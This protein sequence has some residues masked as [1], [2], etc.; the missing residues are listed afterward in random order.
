MLYSLRIFSKIDPENFLYIGVLFFLSGAVISLVP[1][2][3]VKNYIYILSVLGS[4]GFALLSLYLLFTLPL[5][6]FSLPISSIF[7]F[8]FRGDAISGFFVLAISILTLAVSIYSIGY[9]KEMG[10]KGLMG[11]LFN[12]FILSMYAVVLSGNIVTFIMSWETMS[13]VSYFL[14]TFDR[15]E[16][17]AKA[18]LVYA[19]MT[20][21]GTAFIIALFLILYK[22]TASMNFSDIKTLSTQIPENIRHLIFIFSII[23][24]GTKAGIIPLHTWLPIAH[25]AAPSNISSLMSGVMIKTGIYGIIR[26][27]MDILGQGPEWWGISVIVIG[28]V[29]SIIGVMYAL[30][31]HDLKRLLAYHSVENIGIIL[32]GIGASMMFKS[33]GLYTLSSIALIAGLYHVLNHGIFKGLLFL[34]AGSVMHAT[35]TKNMEDMG[36]LLKEMPYTGLFF[37]VGSVSICALPPFNGFV[38]E[39]LTYQSLLLGFKSPSVVSKIIPPLGGAAL[40]LTGALAAACFVKAFGISFLGMP[41]SKHVEDVKESSPLMIAGMGVLALLCLV[42]GI[43]PGFAVNLIAPASFAVTGSY[44]ITSNS[45]FLY[46]TET[47]AGL[48]PMTILFT[49]VI[50]SIATIL[51]IRR[52]GGKRKIVYGD[53][54]DCGIPALTPRMQYTATA[55]TKPIRMIFKRIYLPRREL[56]VSYIVKPF[57]VKSI[58]YSGEITPFFERYIYEPVTVFTHKIAGKVRLLQSGSLHLYLGYILI[59]LILLLIFGS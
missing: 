22:Q 38:S 14:V 10:G 59:T 30:M 32:L 8:S 35:H 45:G 52:L 37:L 25:P 55:F 2:Q 7:E 43:F 42:F 11:F 19:V 20:Q 44:G 50:M 47:S 57:F 24:F 58:K 16:K 31:E 40:A 41:R 46:L 26:I 12:I 6:L 48:S 9:T 34:G 3:K 54:W 51:F 1:I 56:K 49:V 13:I 28:A 17:S 5:N 29:S 33:H 15:D 23:G 39:W 21:I 18:G 4:I 53:S 27:C 36:G